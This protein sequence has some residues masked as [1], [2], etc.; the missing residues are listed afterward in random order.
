MIE[1]RGL[2]KH[3]ADFT[4]VKA[5]SFKVSPGE[6]VGL[7]GV[8]L[9][10]PLA[11][12]PVLNVMLLLRGMRS[13]LAGVLLH[14]VNNAS[15]LLVARYGVDSVVHSGSWLI[16]LALFVVPG[17]AALWLLREDSPVSPSAPEPAPAVAHS[18]V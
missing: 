16:S 3:Y 7:L 12:V 15:V 11:L 8:E 2:T 5:V 9:T 4:A 1:A 10:A 13:I 14:F 17:A 18:Q 6:V